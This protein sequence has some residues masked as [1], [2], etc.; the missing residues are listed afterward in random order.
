MSFTGL[1]VASGIGGC[2]DP[3]QANQEPTSVAEEATTQIGINEIFG[4]PSERRLELGVAS[5]NADPA[6]KA[7]ETEE[8][9]QLTV[10][11]I[12]DHSGLECQDGVEV[13]LEDPLGDR[14]VRDTM[15]GE[16]L[17]VEPPE[18]G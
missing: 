13:I 7:V 10:T 3:G 15:T 14:Q 18:Q 8:E 17:D 4:A 9:V 1:L 5:C 16:I 11:I 2:G 6:V 12:G